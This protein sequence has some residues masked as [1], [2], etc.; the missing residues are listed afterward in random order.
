[1]STAC[2]P[3][4]ADW[5]PLG[6]RPSCAPLGKTSDPSHQREIFFSVI[7]GPGFQA[8]ELA[9]TGGFKTN[10]LIRNCIF[11]PP[12]SWSNQPAA[13]SERPH[14]RLCDHPAQSYGYG[15][16]HHALAPVHATTLDQ[17]VQRV[18]RQ[19]PLALNPCHP[20]LARDLTAGGA[21]L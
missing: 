21:V 14:S 12:N 7:P 16:L 19:S 3:K 18:S 6:L 4:K 17:S 8:N 2:R 1:M 20:E 11:V 5:Q 10:F 13:L 15:G 9:R